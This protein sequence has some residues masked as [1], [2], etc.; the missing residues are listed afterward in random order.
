[1]MASE[2]PED[3]PLRIAH[4]MSSDHRGEI[5]RSQF[6]GCFYCK[7]T[8]G[9]DQIVEWVDDDSTALCPHCG[10]DSV[11]GDASGIKLT[12][13]FLRDMHAVWFS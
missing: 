13:E 5:E 10:I 7:R 4:L 8:F 11:I 12:E 9:P 1:M 3:H 2:L 6:C